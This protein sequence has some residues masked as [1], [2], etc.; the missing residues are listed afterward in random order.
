MVDGLRRRGLDVVTASEVGL[1]SGSDDQH[2]EKATSLGRVI[3]TAD[4]DFLV[5]A[6]E[7]ASNGVPF[8]G[9]LF[10]KPQAAVGEVVRAVIRASVVI[11]LDATSWVCW[12]P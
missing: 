2:M 3:L 12:L 4:R 7:R 11:D 9:L 5:I 6:A 8:P 10:L 1:R